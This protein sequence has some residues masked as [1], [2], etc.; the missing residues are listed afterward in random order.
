[1][2]GNHFLEQSRLRVG[3]MQRNK[4][5][6]GYFI[7]EH[8]TEYEE[9]LILE[10]F[11]RVKLEQKI[12]LEAIRLEKN[13][14]INLENIQ[15]LLCFGDDDV[16]SISSQYKNPPKLITVELPG[17]TSYF[18][19][20]KLQ[21]LEWAFER[22]NRNEYSIDPRDRILIFVEDADDSPLTALNDI[23]ISSSV[24]NVRMR[25]DLLI[26]QRSIYPNLDSANG[27]LVSTPTGSTAMSLNLGGAIIQTNSE[28]FQIQTIASRNSLSR[29]LIVSN[30]SE[31]DVEVVETKMPIVV[32]VDNR[33]IQTHS[34]KFRI[35]RDPNHIVFIKLPNLDQEDTI[36]NKL[37][38]KISFEDTNSL[39]SSAKFVLHILRTADNPMTLTELSKETLIQNQKTLRSS[40]QLLQRQG[41]I[42][43]K[44]N[45]NDLRSHLYYFDD[46]RN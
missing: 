15:F 31:I 27:L 46:M 8:I 30:R 36:Q 13:I 43:R 23:H 40:L 18:A 17:D 34:T 24:T 10:T 32:N 11:D 1:M 44:T 16:L 22:L 42:R 41:F 28:V 9:K 25:Y 21:Q 7:S 29:L 14:R 5:K 2:I 26:D 33:R 12:D 3:E 35:Q 39:T 4:M 20:I 37:E 38:N 6:F 45:L 19:Q